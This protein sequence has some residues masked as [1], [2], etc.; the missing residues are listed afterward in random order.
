M[1]WTTLLS[2]SHAVLVSVVLVSVVLVSSMTKLDSSAATASLVEVCAVELQ[3]VAPPT[4]RDGQGCGSQSAACRPW[5]ACRT[6]V[7]D[8]ADAGGLW[9]VSRHLRVL[10]D[11]GRAAPVANSSI[12]HP[13]TRARDRAASA[14]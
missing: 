14:L 9:S 12:D 8:V 7:A 1:V 6:D 5:T 4:S 2:H 13:T 10:V 11:R 3:A